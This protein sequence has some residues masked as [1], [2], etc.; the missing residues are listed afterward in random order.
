MST[1]LIE[2]KLT[3]SIIGCGYEVYKDLGF[4][5][6]EHVYKMAL[7]RLLLGK[8]HRVGREVSVP[9]FFRGDV[10]TT[11]RLDMIVDDKVVVE[12]KASYRLPIEAGGQLLSYLRCTNIEVGLLLHFG[13]KQFGR[14]RLVASNE[15]KLRDA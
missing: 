11:D 6:R 9:V 8:G 15:F 5:F 10:L 14:F 13:P 4:G 1:P 2:E 3:Y 7:E 12:V